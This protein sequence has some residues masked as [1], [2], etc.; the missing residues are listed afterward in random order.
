M[1]QKLLAVVT[2][3]FFVQ[4]C[5]STYI[6]P[7]EGSRAQ[8]R[9]VSY[10]SG[11]NTLVRSYDAEDCNTGK[12]LV[13]ALSGIAINHNRKKLGLPLGSEFDEKNYTETYIRANRPYIFDMGWSFGSVY[14]G[15]ESCFVT[16]VFEP[17]ENQIYEASFYRDKVKCW[18]DVKRFKNEFGN[19]IPI[20]ES[21]TRKSAMQCKR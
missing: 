7:S 21:T 16:T 20:Q 13:A 18:V 5:A 8:I 6:E 1:T 12:A 15:F 17:A 11:S 4:G 10:T 14:S 2:I 9:F 3:A 19:Y